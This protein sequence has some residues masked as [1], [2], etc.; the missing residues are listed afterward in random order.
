LNTQQA[1]AS[2]FGL[3]AYYLLEGMKTMA[4]KKKNKRRKKSAAFSGSHD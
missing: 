4:K 3:I 2:V 1:E